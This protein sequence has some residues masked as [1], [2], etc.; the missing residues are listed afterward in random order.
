MKK[1]LKNI[2]WTLLLIIVITT[3]SI[4]YYR[5]GSGIVDNAPNWLSSIL[6]SVGVFA[7]AIPII[8]VFIAGIHKLRETI[9]GNER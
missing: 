4:M 8:I 9:C 2:F 1:V 6:V 7:I 5:I 3:G